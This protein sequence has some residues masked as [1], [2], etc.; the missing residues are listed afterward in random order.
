MT[1]DADI[2]HDGPTAFS[3]RADG[4]SGL[5]F[6]HLDGQTERI[7]SE[8]TLPYPSAGYGGS[9]LSISPQANYA[10]AVLYSGQSEVGYELFSLT[11]TLQHIGGMPYVCGESDLTP[12]QFS[13][14]E[15][16]AAIAIE[17]G[18]LWWVDPEDE[19]ADWDTPALGG[20]VEWAGLYVHR[21]GDTQPSRHGLV[22]DLPTGWC[23]SD[24]GTWPAELRFEA[25]KSLSLVVPWDTRFAFAIPH[26]KEPI[27]IPSPKR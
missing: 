9:V 5:T 7:H 4:T 12:I 22:V 16:L 1:M 2:V 24:D 21:L 25:A 19:D 15:R 26:Y 23:P 18:C 27:L 13:T 11:P 6:A 3:I 14:D 10:A 20:R 8:L 17:E